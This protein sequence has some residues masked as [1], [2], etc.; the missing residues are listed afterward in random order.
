MSLLK[1]A[2]EVI[3]K[4]VYGYNIEHHTNDALVSLAD[5]TM[6]QFTLAIVPGAWI[7]D[8]LPFLRCL[9]SW[10]P[11]AGFKKTA[12]DWAKSL[13]DSGHIPYE[14]TKRPTAAGKVRDSF[15]ARSIQQAEKDFN[16]KSLSK[17]EE[18][19]IQWTALTLYLGGAD[20]T[21]ETLHSVYLA[22]AMF[23]NVQ[24]KAQEEIDRVFGTSRLPG[25]E[26]RSNLP[27]I[28]NVVLEAQRWHPIAP[29][30]GPHVSNEED[31]ISGYRIP[32]SAILLPA[33]WWF[34]R[35]PEVYHDAEEFKPERYAAPYDEPSPT[36]VTFGFGRRICP[37]RYL[38][39]SIMFLTIVQSLAVFRISKAP[40]QDGKSNDLKHE[41]RPGMISAVAPFDV[42]IQ[43]RS[44]QHEALIEDTMT[45]FPWEKSDQEA[46][47]L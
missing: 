34:T 25:Y 29:L 41:F 35:D 42:L 15:V 23:P 24:R 10:F 38:A 40:S 27:Y 11:G 44:A 16:T 30:G 3:L 2:G 7:V 31:S 43:P 14:F 32:K 1:H 21:V 18:G 9:P 45:R 46:L 4:L 6:Q 39:D 19:I 20:T 17:D 13:S 47:N 5:R 37:G 8:I 36:D 28:N 22:M 12:S 33:V 26:D